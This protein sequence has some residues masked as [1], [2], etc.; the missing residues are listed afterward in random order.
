MD[1]SVIVVNRNT[2]DILR[3]CLASVLA[4]TAGISFEVIV[5]DNGSTDGSAEM[6]RHEFPQVTLIGNQDNR[7]FAA[8]NNQ[9]MRVARGR[10]VLLLNSD[11]VVLDG[12]I[13]KTVAFADEHPEAAV[14]GCRVLNPDRSLQPTCF[15]F[16]SLPNM[17]L[18]TTYLYKLFPR[19]RFFGRERMT[20]W[21]RDDVREV[22]V[23]TGCFMLVQREAIENVGLMD[24]RFFMYAEETDWCYR[25]KRAGW[26]NLF[27]PG[28]SI[29]H[30]GG[31]S[32]RARADDMNIQLRR[33]IL[34]F[35][36][37][38][39]SALS[40]GAARLLTSLFYATRTPY[41]WVRSLCGTKESRRAAWA[42]AQLYKRGILSMLLAPIPFHGAR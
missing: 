36:K 21:D 11:T 19:N 12:A 25:F 34:Q 2:R 4:E 30:L 33:S 14:V 40:Y 31:G 15:L 3:K 5:V 28:A 8:A 29:V 35:M 9:G 37:K 13:Q 38:H 20:W 17:L 16:P 41:W 1:I 18:S 7:G 27:C 6:V 39:R 10:Y 32:T 42:R 22:E 26:M 23:V 24:E